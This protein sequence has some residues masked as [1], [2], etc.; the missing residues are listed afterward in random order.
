[1]NKKI[2]AGLLVLVLATV[3]CGLPS[4]TTTTT[5]DSN[6]LFQDDFSDTGS[7]WYT[8]S[9]SDGSMDYSNGAFRMLVTTSDLLLF[10]TLGQSFQSDIVID[11]DTLK[12]AGPDDNA[13]GVICRY[14]DT[15]NFYFFVISSDGYAG[16]AKYVNNEL[17]VI[18]GS[19]QME[20]T[21]VISQGASYNHITASCVGSTLTLTVNGTQLY[22]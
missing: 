3:A 20:Y 18:T 4:T 21:D 14:V 11:V 19:G 9:D 6:I 5:G 13:F 2:F 17:S 15:D 8:M 7:G 10:T 22:S 16:I 12:N 1:M